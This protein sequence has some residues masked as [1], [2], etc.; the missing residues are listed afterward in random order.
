MVVGLSRLVGRCLP[1]RA[2]STATVSSARCYVAHVV[3][4][5]NERSAHSARAIASRAL[6]SRRA[7]HVRAAGPSTRA[8]TELAYFD[9]TYLTSISAKVLAVEVSR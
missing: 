4:A 6:S 1:L 3:P 8:K 5:Y 9:D 2:K 7:V